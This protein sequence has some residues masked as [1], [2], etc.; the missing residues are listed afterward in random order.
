[1]AGSAWQESSV[2]GHAYITAAN[3]A[4]AS[5][6]IRTVT[7]RIYC[8]DT[9]TYNLTWGAYFKWFGTT[10]PPQLYPGKEVLVSL[11]C[12][13]NAVNGVTAT[14]IVQV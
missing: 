5:T 3:L 13:A 4:A 11:A 9:G 10:P 2:S 1:M 6:T 8:A 14:T 7:G 12:F